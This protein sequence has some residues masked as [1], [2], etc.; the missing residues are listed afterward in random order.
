MFDS[1]LKTS[2]SWF[3]EQYLVLGL[4]EYPTGYSFFPLEALEVFFCAVYIFIQRNIFFSLPYIP[5]DI[6]LPLQTLEDCLRPY[7]LHLLLFSPK[8]QNP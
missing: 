4:S 5:W 3:L 8:G 7:P 2:A 1:N 6:F